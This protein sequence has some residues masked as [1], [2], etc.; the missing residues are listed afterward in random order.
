[1]AHFVV[2]DENN[3]VIDI[4]VVADSDCLDSDGNQSEEVG[5]AFLTNL[6]GD[7][8]WKLTSLTG[9]FRNKF[10]GIGYSYLPDSDVFVTPEPYPSWSLNDDYDWEAPIAYPDD[11]KHYRWLEGSGEWEEIPNDELPPALKA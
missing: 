2:L 4:T 7:K 8:N 10:A 5:V 11:G 3:I 6:F 9:G 1:M